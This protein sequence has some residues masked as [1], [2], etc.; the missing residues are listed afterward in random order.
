[1][2]SWRRRLLG[3]LLRAVLAP[4]ARH[5]AASGSAEARRAV[6]VAEG[7]EAGAHGGVLRRGRD[8]RRARR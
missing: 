1:M 8:P 4:P 2:Q 7:D 3:A 5:A 6:N